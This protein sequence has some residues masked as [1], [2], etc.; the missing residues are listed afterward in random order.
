MKPIISRAMATLTTLAVLLRTV[1]RRYRA[2]EPDLRFAPDVT[3]DFWQRPDAV[4]L[5]TADASW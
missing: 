3:N 5:V 1:G 2:G 4:N